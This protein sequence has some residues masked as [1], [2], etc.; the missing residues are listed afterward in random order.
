MSGKNNANGEKNLM[1]ERERERERG[2]RKEEKKIMMNN[3][4]TDHTY[5]KE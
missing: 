5:V 1:R 2:K 3:E 4:G